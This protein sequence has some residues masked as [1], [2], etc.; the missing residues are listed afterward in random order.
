MPR[1]GGVDDDHDDEG[2]AAVVEEDAL[3]KQRH[4]A[5]ALSHLSKRRRRASAQ[6]RRIR[7]LRAFDYFL[8]LLCGVAAVLLASSI[9]LDFAAVKERIAMPAAG[10]ERDT[11]VPPLSSS[12]N[13]RRDGD[14]GDALP[15]SGDGGAE[16]TNSQISSSSSSF[17]AA[18]ATLPQTP[19]DSLPLSL[20]RLVS[21]G[22]SLSLWRLQV[23]EEL[24]DF[25]SD[26]IRDPDGDGK[27]VN[28]DGIIVVI[29]DQSKSGED[30]GEDAVLKPELLLAVRSIPTAD[31]PC[32]RLAKALLAGKVISLLSLVWCVGLTVLMFLLATGRLGGRISDSG[33]SVGERDRA[34]EGDARGVVTSS[35]ADA[36]TRTTRQRKR[37]VVVEGPSSL[38]PKCSIR[39]SPSLFLPSPPAPPLSPSASRPSPLPT[40]ASFSSPSPSSDLPNSP[41]CCHNPLISLRHVSFCHH[42]IHA[43]NLSLVAGVVGGTLVLSYVCLM[44]AIFGVPF[45]DGGLQ[46]GGFGGGGGGGGVVL[47]QP[48][49]SVASSSLSTAS[50]QIVTVLLW[51]LGSVVDVYSVG[52]PSAAAVSSALTSTNLIPSATSLTPTALCRP[53]G[54]DTDNPINAS[55]AIGNTSFSSPPPQMRRPVQQPTAA[56]ATKW[57]GGGDHHQN[58][59]GSDDMEH[60][61]SVKGVIGAR[62]G[63]G[64]DSASRGSVVDKIKRDDQDDAYYSELYGEYL[65]AN[66]VLLSGHRRVS[67]GGG[68]GGQ[69]GGASGSSS[70]S[71]LLS[72]PSVACDLFTP[73]SSTL[74]GLRLAVGFYLALTTCVAVPIIGWGRWYAHRCL[75]EGGGVPASPSFGR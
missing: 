66:V 51:G 15:N 36:E 12:P 53:D 62:V 63:A 30:R 68:E 17:S 47:S 46:F 14:R 20:P 28:A 44:A 75:E 8:A 22:F 3:Q 74:E 7:L 27:Y 58:L 69:S 39:V 72:S 35:A 18:N 61:Q 65:K 10:E 21:R 25:S 45:V 67:G 23:V 40:S 60:R 4:D 70:T 64:D 5:E 34:A 73:L 71:S 13:S 24:I 31:L 57:E 43:G 33:S 26:A 37:G 32:P 11:S 19:A 1:S 16:R 9:A 59:S 56:K 38:A 29:N 54:C 6:M 2:A 52:D 42:T 49:S 41:S 50:S 55:T 48:S